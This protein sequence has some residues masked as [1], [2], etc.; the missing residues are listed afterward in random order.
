MRSGSRKTVGLAI[1]LLVLAILAALALSAGYDAQADLLEEQCR[2]LATPVL[3]VE[4]GEGGVAHG[5]QAV[6][7]SQPARLSGDSA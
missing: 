3:G 5:R 4:V 1:A 6:H 2:H 7:G